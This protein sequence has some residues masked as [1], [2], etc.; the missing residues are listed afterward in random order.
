MAPL[1]D[2]TPKSDVKGGSPKTPPRGIPISEYHAMTR[3]EVSLKEY[4]DK[5]LEA[6][7]RRIEQALEA[8]RDAVDKAEK[9]Q[10]RR[11]DLLNEFRGQSSDESKKY[12]LKVVV[13]SLS[14]Q[15]SKLYGGLV[16]VGI[17]GIA[18]LVKLFFSH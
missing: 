18:N 7:D 1:K 8:A 16:V 13:D 3:G 10:E 11:L 17:I 14:T 12:A 15:I 4:F 6:Q 9:A 5:M 2:L